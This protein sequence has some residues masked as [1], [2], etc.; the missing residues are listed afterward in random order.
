MIQIVFVV[1]AFLE[2]N[3]GKFDFITC[4]LNRLA[5]IGLM[6]S[7]HHDHANQNGHTSPTTDK[8]YLTNGH[9]SNGKVICDDMVYYC[10]DVLNNHFH[11][12]QEPRTPN[13]TNNEFPLF[14][15]SYK[16]IYTIHLKIVS[17]LFKLLGIL[18]KKRDYVVVLV[19]FHR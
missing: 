15:N 18:V 2:G 9:G 12:N 5:K 6:A 8:H 11:R 4:F 17:I 14:G 10:F 7:K 13:F 1:V 16:L 3:S 19:H